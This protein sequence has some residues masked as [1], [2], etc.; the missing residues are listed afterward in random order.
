MKQ[1][2]E[3]KSYVVSES[4]KRILDCKML[5]GDLYSMIYDIVEEHDS[6]GVDQIMDTEIFDHYSK[7]DDFLTKYLGISVG[8]N[9]GD[10]QNTAGSKI[11]I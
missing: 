10:L 3:E 11:L 6:A 2:N 7:I 8:L 4:T 5:N 9:I 1:Q